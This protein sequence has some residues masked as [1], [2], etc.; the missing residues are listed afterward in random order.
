MSRL[1]RKHLP[2]HIHGGTRLSEKLPTT[3]S[4]MHSQIY[5]PKGFD[6]KNRAVWFSWLRKFERYE[7][8]SELTQVRL[9]LQLLPLKFRSS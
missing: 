5:P 1:R 4:G 7:L 2:R 8:D 3:I 9:N 6:F